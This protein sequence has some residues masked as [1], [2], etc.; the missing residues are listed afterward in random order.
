MKC[1]LQFILYSVFVMIMASNLVSGAHAD[2][3]PKGVD[4]GNITLRAAAY[5]ISSYDEYMR[6]HPNGKI[7]DLEAFGLPYQ[8]QHIKF[9]V[10]SS[11]KALQ[12]F[13]KLGIKNCTVGYWKDGFEAKNIEIFAKAA[14]AR[15]SIILHN[16]TAKDGE[17]FFESF[18]TETPI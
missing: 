11:P 5:K 9:S 6:T 1:S 15:V 14:K 16:V 17:C 8:A 4:L 10:R 18:A 13:R 3:T 7:A 12:K 2:N